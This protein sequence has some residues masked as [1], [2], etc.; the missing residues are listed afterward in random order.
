M[1]MF[2]NSS[3]N[4]AKPMPFNSP[5]KK[6]PLQENKKNLTRKI[7]QKVSQMALV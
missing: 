6:T 1:P 5:N 2:P 3:S 4:K 7:G